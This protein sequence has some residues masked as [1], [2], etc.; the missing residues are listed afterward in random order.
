MPN[1]EP[2]QNKTIIQKIR[3]TLELTQ[4]E[5]GKLISRGQGSISFYERR[6]DVPSSSTLLLLEKLIKK[7]NLPYSLHDIVKDYSIAE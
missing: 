3:E 1:K 4:A 6:T 7:Y 5:F 2:K